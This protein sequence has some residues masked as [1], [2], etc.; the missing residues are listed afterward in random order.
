MITVYMIQTNK[1]LW[2]IRSS[3]GQLLG[4]K[5]LASIFQAQDYIEKWISS[6]TNWTYEMVP[7]LPTKKVDNKAKL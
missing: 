3:S 7:L 4:E 6:Y 2:E 5:S 1:H